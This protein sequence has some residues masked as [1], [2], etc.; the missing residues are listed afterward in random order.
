M[1]DRPA[2]GREKLCRHGKNL[3]LPMV[4]NLASIVERRCLNPRINE[5]VFPATALGPFWTSMEKKGRTQYAYIVD[6]GEGNAGPLDKAQR[7]NVRVVR[8][9]PWWTPPKMSE[10]R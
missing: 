3:Q 7:A 10:N 6:F 4:P 8:G 5:E 1:R 9:E 2:L